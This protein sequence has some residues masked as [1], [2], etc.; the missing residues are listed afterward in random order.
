MAGN[1]RLV[2][3][4]HGSGGNPWV[5]TDLARELLGDPPGFDRSV[6]PQVDARIVAFFMQHLQPQPTQHAPQLV[7]AA[8]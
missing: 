4:T 1:G 8:P 2:V 7:P 6:L 5:H 3:I